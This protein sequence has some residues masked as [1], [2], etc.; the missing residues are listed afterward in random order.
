MDSGVAMSSKPNSSNSV[1]LWTLRTCITRVPFPAVLSA[2]KHRYYKIFIYCDLFNGAV[3]SPDYIYS[4]IVQWLINNEFKRK[5][6]EAAIAEFNVLSWYLP[7]ETERITKDLRRLRRS[8]GGPWS[9]L[10]KVKTAE[11]GNLKLSTRT[12]TTNFVQQSRSR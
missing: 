2:S 11:K 3:G 9:L 8:P 12:G 1:C 6:K 4:R 7:G 10:L 5:W